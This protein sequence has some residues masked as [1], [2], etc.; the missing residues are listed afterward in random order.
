M[1]GSV[2]RAIYYKQKPKDAVAWRVVPSATAVAIRR[3]GTALV[4]DVS[5]VTVSVIRQVGDSVPEVVPDDTWAEWMVDVWYRSVGETAW[6]MYPIGAGIKVDTAKKGIELRL[7]IANVECYRV[8]VP[9]TFDGQTGKRGAILRGPCDWNDV[10]PG[11]RFE[12]GTDGCEFFDVVIRDGEYYSCAVT[13]TK[14]IDDK[15]NGPGSN[16]DKT[17]HYWQSA[18]DFEF[19]A[20]KLILAK[21]A[22][23]KNLGVESLIM[24]NPDDEE[25][26]PLCVIDNGNI[27]INTGEFKNIKVSGDITADTLALGVDSSTDYKPNGAIVISKSRV[28]LPPVPKY[29]TRIIRVFNQAHSRTSPSDLKLECEKVDGADLVRISDKNSELDSVT[30]LTISGG[31]YNSGRSFELLGINQQGVITYWFV[32]EL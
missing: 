32:N 20:T 10:A 9:F 22:L 31:G 13:H 15:D 7:T 26:D 27:E 2:T 23:I 30:S 19:V 17:N 5:A 25:A 24:P 29:K 18:A 28:V 21:Y 1:K 12:N 8:T 11:A 4:P 3:N 16:L 6:R 14:A